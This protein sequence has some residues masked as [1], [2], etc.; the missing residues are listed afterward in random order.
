VIPPRPITMPLPS[1]SSRSW[2]SLMLSTMISPQTTSAATGGFSTFQLQTA[3]LPICTPIWGTTPGGVSL[4]MA[5]T[6]NWWTPTPTT[7]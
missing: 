7:G 1:Q 2:V 3:S 4:S 6:L 5:R